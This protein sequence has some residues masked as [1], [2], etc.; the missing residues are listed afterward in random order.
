MHVHPCLSEESEP[1]PHDVRLDRLLLQ[2]VGDLRRDAFVR[3]ALEQMITDSHSI[4]AARCMTFTRPRLRF[5]FLA[6]CAR[7]L[8]HTSAQIASRNGAAWTGSSRSPRPTLQPTPPSSPTASSLWAFNREPDALF[9]R[10]N[11]FER[12]EARRR[13]V[14]LSGAPQPSAS[15]QDGPKSS[16]GKSVPL[17]CQ[18]M[19]PSG[20][21][22][23]RSA[24]PSPSTSVSRRVQKRPG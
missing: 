18:V 15:R 9:D 4:H 10:F 13:V 22:A 5:Q 19:R 14:N 17:D 6:A 20:P 3:D 12:T 23:D 1:Y 8:R 24:R 2:L 21:R 16:V 11:G 7:R